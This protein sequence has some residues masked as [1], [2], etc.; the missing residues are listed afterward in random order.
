MIL[1][2]LLGKRAK[3]WGE[4][5]VGKEHVID[6]E[7]VPPKA[8]LDFQSYD[9]MIYGT[10]DV[11]AHHCMIYDLSCWWIPVYGSDATQTVNTTAALKNLYDMYVP[12]VD[13]EKPTD[14][15]TE[16]ES[17]AEIGD[18]D[19]QLYFRP[20]RISLQILTDPSI[21][22]KLYGRR[23]WLGWLEDKGFRTGSGTKTRYVSRHR[24]FVRRGVNTKMPGYIVWVLTIPPEVDNDDFTIASTFPENR[25]FQELSFLAPVWDPIDVTRS[26][27]GAGMDDWRRWAQHITDDE[28]TNSAKRQLKQVKIAC[29]MRRQIRFSRRFSQPATIS[30]DA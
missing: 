23:E 27:R 1:P 14:A 7:A 24:G 30:P 6:W 29:R 15:W 21:P 3:A 19:D 20:D 2:K 12:K 17:D 28:E 4:L 22:T 10:E 13:S 16:S 18:D 11:E 5:D 9:F 26:L 25:S 8:A